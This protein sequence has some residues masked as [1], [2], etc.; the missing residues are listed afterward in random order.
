MSSTKDRTSSTLMRTA[1][2]DSLLGA[3]AH[4]LGWGGSTT[5]SLTPCTFPLTLNPKLHRLHWRLRP[6]AHH[7]KP[8]PPSPGSRQDQ[9]TLPTWGPACQH[10]DQ[11]LGKE[12]QCSDLRDS[13][14]LNSHSTGRRKQRPQRTVLL[15]RYFEESERKAL[16]LNV[17]DSGPRS[18]SRAQEASRRS[19]PEESLHQ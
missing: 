3:G 6:Q 8:K 19:L 18:G 1:L 13:I 7:K 14:F 4:L 9:M 17:L 2:R 11:K 10:P 16:T 15:N 5:A 12:A